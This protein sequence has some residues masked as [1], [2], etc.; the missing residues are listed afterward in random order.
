MVFKHYVEIGPRR[1]VDLFSLKLG[2]GRL[3]KRKGKDGK[4]SPW[5]RAT[6]EPRVPSETAG[7]ALEDRAIDEI[8]TAIKGSP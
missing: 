3:V 8:T 1:Y 2:S 6:A 5:D 4:I 7:I